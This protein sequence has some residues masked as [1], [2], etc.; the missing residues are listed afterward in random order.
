MIA[1]RFYG[2]GS[3]LQVV[4]DTIRFVKSTVTR[5]IDRETVSLVARKGQFIS[6]PDNQRK[7]VIRARF[8][9]KNGFPNVVGCSD[10]THIS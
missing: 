3:H 5:V 10:G 6:W 9:E 1:L 2:S 8:Y 4:W 7:N